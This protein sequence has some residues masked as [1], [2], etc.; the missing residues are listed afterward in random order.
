MIRATPTLLLL[1]PMLWA[2][3]AVSEDGRAQNFGAPIALDAETSL[4]DV[5]SH[6]E[7]YA[8][9]PVLIKGRVTDVCQKRGCWT[10]LA[11]GD[12]RVRIRFKN[13]GFFLPR[14]ATGKLA[15]AEGEVRVE[16]QSERTARHYASESKSE[17]PEAIVGER[18]VVAFTASGV[19]LIDSDN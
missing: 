14:D 17:D 18:R 15:L 11:D 8:E 6:P 16:V 3:I 5:I 4:K 2:G 13:Y 1:L 10:V 9:G 7:R 19:R 12:A